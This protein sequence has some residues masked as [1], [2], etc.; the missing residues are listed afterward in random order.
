MSKGNMGVQVLPGATETYPYIN[1]GMRGVVTVRGDRIEPQPRDAPIRPAGRPLRGAKITEF[2]RDDDRKTYTLKYEIQ[3]KPLTWN[4]TIGR[5]G[6]Y[7]F[8]YGDRNGMET[9]ETYRRREGKDG[10]PTKKDGKG[11]PPKKDD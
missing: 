5:D 4:Y 1:G 2:T 10:P 9:T 6:V 11:P 3:G 7:T 8:V